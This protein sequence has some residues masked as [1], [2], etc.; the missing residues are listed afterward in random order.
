MDDVLIVGPCAAGKSTLARGLRERGY[1]AHLVAQEHSGI[2][3]LWR[4]HAAQVL[5]Y[6][7]VDIANVQRRGRPDFPEWLHQRQRQRLI[8]AKNAAH[9]YVDTAS[10]AI[11]DVLHRVLVF[12]SE[13]N[14]TPLETHAQ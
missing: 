7:D 5:V 11:P 13:H 8:N 3:D 10:L 14:I 6:L 12:L 9:C 4:K 1:R 2:R